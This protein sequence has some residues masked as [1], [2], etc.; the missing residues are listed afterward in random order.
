MSSM[1]HPFQKCYVDFCRYIVVLLLPRST[2]WP[3]DYDH[4]LNFI[5]LTFFWLNLLQTYSFGSNMGWHM[6]LIL[7]SLVCITWTLSACRISILTA[8][9]GGILCLILFSI[10]VWYTLSITKACSSRSLIYC[11][12]STYCGNIC[13]TSSLSK[14]SSHSSWLWWY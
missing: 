13:S 1:H 10:L 3:I 4:L 6:C 8:I 7:D 9:I 14:F 5:T 2:K 11:I 12:V